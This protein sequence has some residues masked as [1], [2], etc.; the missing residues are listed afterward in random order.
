MC[1]K[2]SMSLDPS[3]ILSLPLRVLK[4]ASHVHSSP[5]FFLQNILTSLFHWMNEWKQK[6]DE[7]KYYLFVVVWHKRHQQQQRLKAQTMSYRFSLII[8]N[9]FPRLLVSFD[10]INRIAGF[11]SLSFSVCT[12]WRQLYFV[13]YFLKACVRACRVC[14]YVS[15]CACTVQ[16]K[17]I[18]NAYNLDIKFD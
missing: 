1:I 4:T 11:S 18:F 10:F 16:A 9:C 7:H 5:C 6:T 2:N 3:F 15:T 17:Y 13:I 8:L 14:M 12:P